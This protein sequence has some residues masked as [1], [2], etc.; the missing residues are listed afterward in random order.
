MLKIKTFALSLVAVMGLAF[1]TSCEKPEGGKVDNNAPK[2]NL[3]QTE[4]NVGYEGGTYR[5]NFT[6]TNPV[7][8][9]ST[10]ATPSENW[11][12]DVFVDD[13]NG[14]I[15]FDVATNSSKD[16]RSAV[17]EVNYQG[18]EKPVQVTIAQSGDTTPEFEM[19][20]VETTFREVTFD[21]L[22]LHKN[23]TY[24]MN[25]NSK[26][27]IID[28][29]LED[30]E[31][32][33]QD[34]MAYFEYLGYWHGQ[35]AVEIMA[36]RAKEGDVIE[37]V[38]TSC[39]PGTDYV[40]YAYYVDLT[41]GT[42]TSDITRFTVTTRAV[43][44]TNVEFEIDYTVNEAFVDVEIAPQDYSGSYY[45][46]M[47]PADA[48]DAYVATYGV[49]LEKYFEIW[50]N[51]NVTNDINNGFFAEEIISNYCS[52]GSDS[53][54]FDL[55]QTTRY[56]LVSFAV[57]GHAYCASTP[58]FLEI[59]TSTVSPSDLVVTPYVNNI[60]SIKAEIGYTASNDD[61]YVSGLISAEE[62]ETLGSSEQAKIASLIRLMDPITTST[63]SYKG[64][65]KGLTPETEYVVFAFGFRG[66][67]ATTQMYTTTFTTLSDEPGAADLTMTNTI[68][69]FD[70]YDIAE[71]YPTYAGTAQTYG[72]VYA[73][74]PVEFTI[75]PLGSKPY[76]VTYTWDSK[77][78][79]EQFIEENPNY[80]IE[81]LLR[82]GVKPVGRQLLWVEYGKYN[83]II[84]M[85]EDSEGR[86]SEMHVTGFDVSKSGVSDIQL[87][88]DWNE[89]TSNVAPNYVELPQDIQ[90]AEL[91][92]SLQVL[93]NGVEADVE[94]V[95]VEND[96]VR[97]SS[98]EMVSEVIPSANELS[99]VR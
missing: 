87:F 30:D 12:S 23:R 37:Q 9:Q 61:P 60:R 58:K 78:H 16:S 31:A 56:Y 66:G 40:L 43:E 53:H 76:Y 19:V 42:R 18:V 6:I 29:G 93:S 90:S 8:G 48:A 65:V 41:D 25:V 68:G 17:L 24:V 20:N 26:N 88:V 86:Y 49:T 64:E 99:P 36:E 3:E 59:T 92:S 38:I 15:T 28:E 67:V 34:D 57:E 75:D 54:V 91:T 74:Y 70:L 84:Y 52:V 27:Y 22:P 97:Y 98:V 14:V 51:S 50:W 44:L 82:D 5:I 81:Q 95:A 7:E 73:F 89:G 96:R 62:F 33:F 11:I 39:A 46:D 32:L 47:L 85:A 83:T 79:Y 45:F 10:M 63:G 35:S 71:V 1:F 13:V 80:L 77:A 94:A 72:D 69:Y 21:L 55:L 4:L 2:I